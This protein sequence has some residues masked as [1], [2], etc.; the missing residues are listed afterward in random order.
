MTAAVLII[1][2]CLT[3]GLASMAVKCGFRHAQERRTDGCGRAAAAGKAECHNESVR[4]W[5][6]G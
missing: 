3:V 4:R 1:D 6:L 5:T 2:E